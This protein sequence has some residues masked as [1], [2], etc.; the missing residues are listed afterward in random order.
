MDGPMRFPIFH[1]IEVGT[2]LSNFSLPSVTRPFLRED[3][4]IGCTRNLLDMLKIDFMK[5]A[6]IVL[7]AQDDGAYPLGFDDPSDA[8][9]LSVVSWILRFILCIY[10]EVWINGVVSP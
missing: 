4:E 8:V 7:Q 5:R 6:W 9:P 1:K 3:E 10:F 2:L